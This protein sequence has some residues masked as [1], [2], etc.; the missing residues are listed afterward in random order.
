[1][2]FLK[3]VCFSVFA[4]S[5]VAFAAGEHES[6]GKPRHGGVVSVVQDMGY[7]LV[8]TKDSIRIYLDDHGKA[9]DING[10][11]AK[12]TLLSGTK[13]QEVDLKSDGTA[14]EAKGTYSVDPGTKAV[15]QINLKNKPTQSV[16]F[17]LK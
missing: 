3:I 9:P 16:R 8:A 15:A 1:M 4:F 10:A 13:K 17:T 12:L 5:G 11:T 14:L 6:A 7:E 2:Q